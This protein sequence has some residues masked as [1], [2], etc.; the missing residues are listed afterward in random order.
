MAR[1]KLA[2]ARAE[3]AKLRAPLA[4]RFF[5]FRLRDVKEKPKKRSD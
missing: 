5:L 3:N 1:L 2:L 4:L